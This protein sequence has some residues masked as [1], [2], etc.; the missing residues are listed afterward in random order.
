[1]KDAKDDE[2]REIYFEHCLRQF[3]RSFIDL[4][5]DLSVKED[6]DFFRKFSIDLLLE[7]ILSKPECEEIILQGMVNKLGD[8]NN[9]I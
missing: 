8:Q 6:F 3:Y 9:K 1:M 5:L 7:A 4:V 2:L